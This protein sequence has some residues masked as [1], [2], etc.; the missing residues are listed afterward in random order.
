MMCNDYCLELGEGL[1]RKVLQFK[2]G[3]LKSFQFFVTH[4]QATVITSFVYK[5]FK[6]SV[7]AKTQHT[8]ILRSQFL[9][10]IGY[11]SDE[12]HHIDLYELDS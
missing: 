7:L 1:T 6:G 2:S 9:E 4:C 12:R 10:T 3:T 5:L 11:G 8:N